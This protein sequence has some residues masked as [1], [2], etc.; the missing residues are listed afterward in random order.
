MERRSDEGA[1][2]RN[3]D[4]IVAER[5]ES[6]SQKVGECTLLAVR[7]GWLANL[8]SMLIDRAPVA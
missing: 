2:D 5:A 6:A 3:G 7:I 1:A 8:G 4:G